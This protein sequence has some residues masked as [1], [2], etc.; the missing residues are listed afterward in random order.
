ME[1]I[2]LYAKKGYN[3]IVSSDHFN[4]D[5]FEHFPNM[6]WADQIEQ[7]MLG[8]YSASILGKRYGLDVFF[9]IEFRETSSINDFIVLGLDKDFLLKHEEMYRYSLEKAVGCFHAAGAL[10]IQAHPY[11]PGVNTLAN[12]ALLDGIEVYNGNSQWKYDTESAYKTAKLYNLIGLS[13]SDTHL[14][15]DV[16]H[17]GIILNKKPKDIHELI[18]LIRK[19]TF[20]LIEN[21]FIPSQP[22]LNADD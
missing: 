6:S 10:V 1:L 5:F 11:R 18:C 3:G 4:L 15:E 14:S 21:K 17:G 9:G 7:Y 13:G 16:G 2:R 12:P 22:Y 8:F 19:K 20:T